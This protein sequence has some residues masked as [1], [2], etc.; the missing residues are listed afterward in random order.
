MPIDAITPIW[1]MVVAMVGQIVP[2][3]YWWSCV[4]YS[5]LLKVAKNVTGSSFSR[6]GR[7]NRGSTSARAWVVVNIV[8][9]VV[10]IVSVVVL[11]VVENVLRADQTLPPYQC[12]TAVVPRSYRQSWTN[13]GREL[14]Q[15]SGG[16]VTI[17]T[18]RGSLLWSGTSANNDWHSVI[19]ALTCPLRSK[20]LCWPMEIELTCKT[21]SSNFMLHLSIAKWSGIHV[22][23]RWWYM[24]G[25]FGRGRYIR[26][27]QIVKSLRYCDMYLLAHDLDRVRWYGMYFVDSN[28]DLYSASVTAVMYSISIYIWPCYN[29]TR[30]YLGAISV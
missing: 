13:R 28:R 17:M 19:W 24:M 4:A 3:T 20:C 10:S 8:S 23:L 14:R 26:H 22:R 21:F 29:S 18:D 16:F 15:R 7:F 12:G 30:L 11:M 25:L 5:G 6:L 2:V 9:A 1:Y 27:K